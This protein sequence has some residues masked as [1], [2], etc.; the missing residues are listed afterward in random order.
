MVLNLG[1]SRARRATV[2][3]KAKLQHAR[4]MAHESFKMFMGGSAD[5]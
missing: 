4:A 1:R 5:D 3:V 2:G